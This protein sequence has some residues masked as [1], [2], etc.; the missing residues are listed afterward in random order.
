MTFDDKE[1]VYTVQRI[2]NKTYS[3]QTPS[4]IYEN[5]FNKSYR[6]NTYPFAGITLR[7]T[8]YLPK[9]SFF[10]DSTCFVL[11]LE[12]LEKLGVIGK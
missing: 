11:V 5:Y 8:I 2:G 6:V 12:C 1:Y 7:H 3:E 9:L 10:N 4:N